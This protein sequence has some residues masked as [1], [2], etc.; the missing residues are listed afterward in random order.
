VAGRGN[1]EPVS[2][3]CGVEPARAAAHSH[4]LARHAATEAV[5]GSFDSAHTAITRACGKVVG[6]RQV[7]QLTIAA[8]G[9]IDTFYRSQ[10]PQPATD[11]T[12]LCLSVDGKGVV[13]V[14]R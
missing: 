3:R 11:D 2:G 6:K 7:E 1:K 12:L 8:A 14:R 4:T 5:R 9:D 13:M 10:T